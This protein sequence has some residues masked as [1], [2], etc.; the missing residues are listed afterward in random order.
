MPKHVFG[1]VR[2]RRLGISLGIDVVPP[3]TC[4]YSCV[5]CQL[6]KTTCLSIE[7][8]NY[9]DPNT[10]VDEVSKT[11]EK[12]EIDFVTILGCGE[13][14]LYRDLGKLVNGLRSLG[15]RVAVLTNGSL[16]WME[17][18][19]MDLM[20]AHYVCT[21]LDA[22]D[23]HLHRAV[24]RPH[25]ELRF[26]KIVEGIETFS[27]EY[28]GF[29]GIEIMLV[30]DMN[31]GVE[32]ARR[33]AEHLRRFRVD[34][35]YVAIPTR[36]PCE[37]FVEPP[38]I[39]RIEAF[40]KIIADAVGSERVATLIEEEPSHGFE[41][42]GDIVE[43]LVSIA[44]IHPLRVDIAIDMVRRRGYDPKILD[45]LVARGILRIVEYMGRKY[46]TYPRREHV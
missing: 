38:P 10:I 4:S 19:R 12:I 46:L 18:V 8:R 17:D 36:P 14:T 6:G 34:R 42:L 27:K 7:R 21:K 3:K 15:L 29:L 9:V 11:V 45:E 30:K 35:V 40:R 24:N 44:A 37:P 20:D 39:E 31:D 5:Y 23:P 32:N 33:I 1:P 28:R 13:P 41:A 25:P 22:G 16:L 43:A 26:E 2:S